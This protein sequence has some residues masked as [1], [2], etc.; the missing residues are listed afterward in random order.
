MWAVWM[1][2]GSLCQ[3]R[4]SAAQPQRAEGAC[5][6]GLCEAQA[7]TGGTARSSR[8]TACWP[9][10]CDKHQDRVPSL[11]AT[12]V[13]S[14]SLLSYC[15]SLGTVLTMDLPGLTMAVNIFHPEEQCSFQQ[16]SRCGAC[17]WVC[18]KDGHCFQL[19]RAKTK[20]SLAWLLVPVLQTARWPPANH[21]TSL[22]LSLAIVKHK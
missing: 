7:A 19:G 12:F 1:A 3:A 20:V 15:P 10:L 14:I 21:F 6:A 9:C 13:F 17:V 22:Q 16:C 2:A 18:W 5:Q 11:C 4:P 8:G